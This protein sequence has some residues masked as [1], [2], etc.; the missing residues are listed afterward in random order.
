MDLISF[1]LHQKTA[2]QFF[3]DIR[4]GCHRAKAAGLSQRSGFGR[5]FLRHIFYRIFHGGDQRTFC[6]VCRW[7]RLSLCDLQT[8]YTDPA[9]FFPCR[10]HRRSLCKLRYVLRILV[11]VQIY[12]ARIVSFLPARHFCHTATGYKGFSGDLSFYCDFL[13]FTRRKE[14][15]HKPPHD[16]IINFSFFCAHILKTHILFCR[17]DCMMVGH[18]RIIHKRFISLKLLSGQ[19]C[20]QFFIRSNGTGRQTF[21]ERS[22][23]ICRQIPGICSWIGQYL[24]LLI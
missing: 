22:H 14:H 24:M 4:P 21:T 2:K 11:F 3:N 16:H 18:F 13:T 10:K 8:L 17:N 7:L 12:I 19:L 1:F 23:H 5:I 15:R 9:V 20:S 6:K